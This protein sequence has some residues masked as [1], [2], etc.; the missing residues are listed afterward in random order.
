MSGNFYVADNLLII[1]SLYDLQKQFTLSGVVKNLVK[2]IFLTLEF[3]LD[4]TT[5]IYSHPQ[6]QIR[7]V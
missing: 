1:N 5:A 7:I 3:Y 4:V 2:T 6:K